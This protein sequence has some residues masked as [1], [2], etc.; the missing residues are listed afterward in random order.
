MR[1]G[2]PFCPAVCLIDLSELPVGI[3]PQAHGRVFLICCRG[4]RFAFGLADRGICRGSRSVRIALCSQSLTGLA[5]APQPGGF[6]WQPAGLGLGT[7]SVVVVPGLHQCVGDV[8]ATWAPRVAP[9]SV[10]KR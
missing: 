4:V 10:E 5:S 2:L 6:G 7:W 8:V 1:G 9:S 3:F